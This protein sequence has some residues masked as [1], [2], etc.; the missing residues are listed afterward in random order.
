MAGP[1]PEHVA[2]TARAALTQESGKSSPASRRDLM[3]ETLR[4]AILS[5]ELNEGA[6]YPAPAIAAQ[7]GLSTTPVREAMIKLADDHLISVLPN[8]GFLVTNPTPTEIDDILDARLLLEVPA[9]RRLAVTG[10]EDLDYRRLHALASESV[11]SAE[12]LDLSSNVRADLE[13][14][15]GL[16]ELAGNREVT[17]MVRSLRSRWRLRGLGSPEKR[18]ALLRSAHEHLD[19]LRLVRDQRVDEAAALLESHLVAAGEV[20]KAD[21][22]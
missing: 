20:W 17:R 15:V 18:A 22:S 1:L 4:S 3:V 13:F 21:A 2:Q 19:I 6:I 9:V 14:H 7:L 5:G 10:V 12:T 16:V 11:A 8:R